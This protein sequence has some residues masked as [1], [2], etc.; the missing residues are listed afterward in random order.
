MS[1]KYK[2]KLATLPIMVKTVKKQGW[3]PTP[4]YIPS[5]SYTMVRV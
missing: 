1:N 5:Y 3:L 4:A 2:E